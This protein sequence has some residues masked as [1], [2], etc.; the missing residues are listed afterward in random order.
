ME[1]AGRLGPR[2]W[3]PPGGLGRPESFGAGRGESVGGPR[4]NP[5]GGPLGVFPG[6]GAPDSGGTLGFHSQEKGGGAFPR[7][8]IPGFLGAVRKGI[9]GPGARKFREALDWEQGGGIGDGL[10]IT[11]GGKKGRPP[12]APGP[13]GPPGRI[14][15]PFQT[16]GFRHNPGR[17]KAFGGG[18]IVPAHGVE[19]RGQAPAPISFGPGNCFQPGGPPGYI[20][21]LGERTGPAGIKNGRDSTQHRGSGGLG[22]FPGEN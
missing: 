20:G 22:N 16:P 2:V 17:A 15:F 8:P 14:L 5:P 13:K 19:G 4:S 9:R 6:F 12:R 10:S 18:E 3:W 11:G 1:L 7:N 21:T